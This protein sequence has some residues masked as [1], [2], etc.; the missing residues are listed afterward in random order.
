[1]LL[2]LNGSEQEVWRGATIKI[3]ELEGV[4]LAVV[5]VVRCGMFPLFPT[6]QLMK[7]SYNT[8][9]WRDKERGP[10][11]LDEVLWRSVRSMETIW[12]P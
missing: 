5:V 12:S 3:F 9:K 6:T 8:L 10:T 1:M 2:R 4:L 11:P 7:T